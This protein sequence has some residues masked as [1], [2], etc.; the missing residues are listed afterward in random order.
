MA[1]SLVDALNRKRAHETLASKAWQDF[2]EELAKRIPQSC[3]PFATHMKWLPVA[4]DSEAWKLPSFLMEVVRCA[5]LKSFEDL[6]IRFF[7]ENEA[8]N[9]KFGFASPAD[10]V[11][12][13]A[14]LNA[15]WKG[16]VH[17]RIDR[18]GAPFNH[19]IQ[20]YATEIVAAELARKLS[21][22]V[23]AS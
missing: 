14:E 4:R 22:L 21:D 1:L 19:I 16:H 10:L 11:K 2:A 3:V 18:N 17:M 9:L 6:W 7:P 5:E 8:T 20:F 12:Q 13:M 23:P 15:A